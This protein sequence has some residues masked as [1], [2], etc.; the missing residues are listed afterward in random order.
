M[1]IKFWGVRGSYPTARAGVLRYGGNTSCVSVQIG[2]KLLVLDAG[3]GVRLLGDALEPE[4]TDIYFLLTHL[5]RDHIDGFPFFAPLYYEGRRVHLLDYKLDG[6]PWSLKSMLDGVYY[7]M[8]PASI[9][10]VHN[11]V[12]R[13]PMK[14][15]R[16]Q[17]FDI[18]RLNLNHPGGAYGYRIAHEGKVFVHIPDNELDPPNPQ[19]PFEDVVAFCA[20]ADFL[21]HDAMYVSAEL[22]QK[23]G[24]GHSSVKQACGL[25]SAAKVGH[26]ALFHHAPERDDEHI[27]HLQDEARKV[28]AIDAIQCTAAFEGL[29]VD[30]GK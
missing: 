30:L 5:H 27:D 22:P 6:K 25:A 17:G 14:Y 18:S 3:S 23:R 10:A 16:S 24:W 1:I 11:R 8:K 21:S 2:E 9:K 15:L 7:P 19:T 20:G 26:L 13:G 29:T 4:V 28:L 12:K